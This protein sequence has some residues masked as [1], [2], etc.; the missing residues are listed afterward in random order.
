[1]GFA[2]STTADVIH[3]RALS[4]AELFGGKTPAGALIGLLEQIC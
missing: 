4:F 3:E 1:M 2:F